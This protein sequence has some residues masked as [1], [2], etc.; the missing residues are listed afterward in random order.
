MEGD[1][2]GSSVQ[3]TSLMVMGP[4]GAETV[5]FNVRQVGCKLRAPPNTSARRLS[6]RLDMTIMVP[7][8]HPS[9]IACSAV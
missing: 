2:S 6:A 4:M 1:L 5:R 3:L 9:R 8:V 7:S